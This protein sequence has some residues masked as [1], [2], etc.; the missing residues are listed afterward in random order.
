[1]YYHCPL[2]QLFKPVSKAK[3]PLKSLTGGTSHV[4]HLSLYIDLPQDAFQRHYC[5]VSRFRLDERVRLTCHIYELQG[6]ESLQE[7]QRSFV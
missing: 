4:L 6:I 7:S 2:P 3:L 5:H 1:M